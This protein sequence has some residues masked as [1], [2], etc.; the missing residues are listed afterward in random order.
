[1]KR[2]VGEEATVRAVPLLTGKA[3]VCNIQPLLYF[4]PILN[5]LP[6][7]IFGLQMLITQQMQQKMSEL[8][9]KQVDRKGRGEVQ[10]EVVQLTVKMQ[11]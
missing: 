7:N 2:N 5:S 4:I 1:M 6:T 9:Q 8:W 10:A 11:L 3:E